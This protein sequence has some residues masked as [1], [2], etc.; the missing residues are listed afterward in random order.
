MTLK[1]RR[2]GIKKI[3]KWRDGGENGV[4]S[5]LRWDGG[6]CFCSRPVISNQLLLT[7]SRV[8]FVVLMRLAIQK[9]PVSPVGSRGDEGRINWH[10]GGER[11]RESDGDPVD[12]HTLSH[13]IYHTPFYLMCHASHKWS[14]GRWRKW[15]KLYFRG[16]F[17]ICVCRFRR[18]VSCSS[19]PVNGIFFPSQFFLQNSVRYDYTDL[20]SSTNPFGSELL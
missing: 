6:L 18:W 1:G 13:A 11:W 10:S 17:Y 8:K 4:K 12:G 20:K 15:Q 19:L 5:D 16:D 9:E 7:D 2:A 3:K 14:G